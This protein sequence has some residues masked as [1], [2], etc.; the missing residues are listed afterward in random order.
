MVRRSDEA[1]GDVAASGPT[2][3]RILTAR[4]E[5]VPVVADDADEL[6]EVF[7]DQRLYVFLGG[8]PTITAHI[9]PDHH[10]SATVAA[11]AGLRPTGEYRDHEGVGE[12]LWRRPV[13]GPPGHIE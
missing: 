12:Q 9:R 10:A 7:G 3:E 4:L 6:I 5:L 8:R 2:D 13:E 1:R 11:R